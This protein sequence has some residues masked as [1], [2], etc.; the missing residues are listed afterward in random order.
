ML[1]LKFVLNLKNSGINQMARDR[2]CGLAMQRRRPAAGRW[3][4]R[5]IDPEPTFMAA[6]VDS[7]GGRKRTFAPAAESITEA[8]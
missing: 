4:T 5:R 6:P 8:I 7:R 1:P 2:I 3:G